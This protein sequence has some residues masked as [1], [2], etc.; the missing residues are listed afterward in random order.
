MN[1]SGMWNSYM[2]SYKDEGVIGDKK[3]REGKIIVYDDKLGATHTFITK[4]A[5]LVTPVVSDDVG[6]FEFTEYKF[7]FSCIGWHYWV[8]EGGLH[9]VGEPWVGFITKLEAPDK[10]VFITVKTIDLLA[11]NGL[12]TQPTQEQR[13]TSKQKAVDD[14]G[15][16][17]K[18]RYLAAE[19]AIGWIIGV[20]FNNAARLNIA[21]QDIGNKKFLKAEV[22]ISDSN[23]NLKKCEIWALNY[24]A[25]REYE[26]PENRRIITWVAIIKADPD[27]PATTDILQQTRGIFETLEFTKW[28]QAVYPDLKN[29]IHR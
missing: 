19:Q 25:Y 4:G 16:S 18:E 1:S 21:P 2:K 9:K 17:E 24:W 12:N 11:K 3:T 29:R 14:L 7:D 6:T 13:T 10:S 27:V 20:E 8:E 26:R 28:N 23:M 5:T 15:M 22:D